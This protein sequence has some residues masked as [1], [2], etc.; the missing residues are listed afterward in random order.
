MN[1]IELKNLIGLLHVTCIMNKSCTF[2]SLTTFKIKKGFLTVSLTRVKKL[3]AVNRF[4]LF[5]NKNSVSPLSFLFRAHFYSLLTH[6]FIFA[7]SS[8]LSPELTPFLCNS[9]CFTC[10]FICSFSSNNQD[11]LGSQLHVLQKIAEVFLFLISVL[12]FIN[13]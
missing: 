5:L 9:F 7:H 2:Y 13:A 4:G 10:P 3:L 12:L 8:L 1:T 6:K 11:P